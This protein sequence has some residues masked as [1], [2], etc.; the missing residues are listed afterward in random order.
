MLDGSGIGEGSAGERG[1][2]ERRHGGGR[3]GVGVG[4]GAPGTTAASGRVLVGVEVQ[5]AQTHTHTGPEGG[6]HREKGRSWWVEWVV[7]WEKG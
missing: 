1:A 7:G 4:R 5:R 6:S 3:R 2:R